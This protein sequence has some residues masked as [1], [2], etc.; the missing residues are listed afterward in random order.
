MSAN[1][2][3]VLGVDPGTH[4]TGYGVIT[5]D[6]TRLLCLKSGSIQ[7]R[8]TQ[9]LEQRLR[10]V[11]NQLISVIDETHPD[12]MAVEGIFYAKNVRSAVILAHARGVVLLAATEK[13]LPVAEYAP[14]VVKQSTVGYGRAGKDQ[15]AQMIA[16]L[17]RLPPT[18]ATRHDATDALAVALCHLNTGKTADRIEEALAREP[19]RRPSRRASNRWRSA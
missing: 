11:Y 12:V 9:P 16:R 3:I 17:F 4:T 15:I 5:Q 6:G 10:T 1:S 7:C 19:G 2:R 14:A 13:H 8:S 18:S